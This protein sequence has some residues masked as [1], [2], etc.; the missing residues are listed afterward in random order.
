MLPI[1]RLDLPGHRQGWMH[2]FQEGKASIAMVPVVDVE[3]RVVG[4]LLAHELLANENTDVRR[5]ALR[6]PVYEYSLVESGKALVG[7]QERML[8]TRHDGIDTQPQLCQRQ[9][10]LQEGER[11]MEVVCAEHFYHTHF[12]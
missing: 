11:I 4:G 10:T 8:L 1:A 12:P 2:L 9:R 5:R 6:S 3:H 7:R